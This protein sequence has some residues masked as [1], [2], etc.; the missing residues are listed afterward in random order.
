MQCCTHHGTLQSCSASPQKR[1]VLGIGKEP[2]SLNNH[3][4]AIVDT[5]S[6]KGQRVG[7][8]TITN[9]LPMMSSMPESLQGSNKVTL[10]DRLLCSNRYARGSESFRT[11]ALASISKEEACSTYWTARSKDDSELLW[12]PTATD[13]L[14]L[15]STLLNI[16][17]RNTEPWLKCFTLQ[18]TKELK[19][20]LNS[21]RTAALPRWPHMAATSSRSLR[22]SQ[23]GTMDEEEEEE[24]IR[25]RKIRIYPTTKQLLLFNQMI[26]A[27]RYIYNQSNAKVIEL[28]KETKERRLSELEELKSKDATPTCCHYTYPKRANKDAP[29]PTPLRCS[30]PRDEG[31]DWFCKDHQTN[32]SL[33]ISYADFL[34][35]I[36][37]RPLVMKS[38][39]DISDNNPDAWLKQI[40]YDT[41]QGAVKE[42]VGA[43]KSAFALKRGGHIKHFEMHFKKKKDV[44]QVFHCRANAI[45]PEELSIFKMRLGKKGC[46][47][48]TRRRDLS[49]FLPRDDEMG[50]SDFT[51]QKMRPG[52]WYICLPRK[53]KEKTKPVYENAAYKACFIDPGVRTFGSFYSP[54]GVC[55]KYGDGFAKDHLEPIADRI[56]N[57]TSM[58]AS[59]IHSESGAKLTWRTVQ[60]MK[61]RCQKLRNK[62]KHKVD[63]LH[64]K[65]CTFLT[66]AFQKIFIPAFGVKDMVQKRQ[67]NGRSRVIGCSTTRRMLEL[68][69]GRFLER[70]KYSAKTKQREVYIVPESYTTKTCGTCGV[71]NPNVGGKHVFE[72]VS[73]T[74]GC[75]MDRDLHAA[76]N[77]CLST[78]AR[79]RR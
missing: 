73:P 43:Y 2:S 71:V 56:H 5:S 57:L 51:I 76:R 10:K 35:L 24:L 36:K 33:G 40:P 12:C 65:T 25:C 59:R 52:A 13:L 6:L 28:M 47:L 14:D 72:C 7:L 26:G 34:S 17:S 70:L 3:P 55:G 75:K 49:K 18:T 61:R 21:Q 66:T 20:E 58:S 48:R 8:T 32:G 41:R 30:K 60:N 19:E 38:D 67:T 27:S 69:H 79:M 11:S 9:N 15:D 22:F 78:M 50:H 68:A 1:F 4:Q 44:K 39:K 46:K 16:S 74:C 64:W 54:E 53:L 63:D 23:L 77:I 45:N 42:L 62:I 37:L 29:S 31:A